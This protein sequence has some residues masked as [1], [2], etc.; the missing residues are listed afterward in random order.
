ME[1]TDLQFE[2]AEFNEA[3]AATV[4]GVCSV[5]L[6]DVY[7]EAN[8]QTV[9]G[10]CC[11]ALRTEMTAGTGVTRAARAIG[12]GALATIGGSILYW[13]I[14]AMTG[15][16]FGLIAILVGVAVGKAVN[17]GSYGR[18]G[19]KYQGLAMALTYMSIVSAYVP[20]VVQE[21]RKQP[22]A[23]A[24]AAQTTEAATPAAATANEPISAG[25]A[26]FAI[27]VLVGLVLA[28]P[29]LSGI[30]NIV[31]IIIIGIG[32][33][34]AWK[35]NRKRVIAITGPHVIAVPQGV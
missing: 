22:D 30:E 7:Y 9:C 3:S 13:A 26:A 23:V 34:E 28:L 18:G 27:L 33:Y 16:E 1:S 2:K 12:A 20:I 25:G 29:F 8:G 32:L 15:Y 35:F 11:E 17:W 14:L 10:T 4:C 21:M 31:G 24:A 6:R 5:S 19:W